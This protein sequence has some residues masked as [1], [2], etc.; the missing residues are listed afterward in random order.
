MRKTVFLIPFLFYTVLALSQPQPCGQNPEMTS[1]CSTACVVCDIDGFTGINDLTAQGQGFDEFMDLDCT[2]QFNNMQYIA[3]IAGSTNLTIEVDVGQCTGGWPSLEVGFFESLDCET[4]TAITPCDTDIESFQSQTFSNYDP[5]VIG[6]HYYLVIDGSGGANCQWTFNVLEGTTEVL[7][8][9]S[10]GVIDHPIETCP[11]QQITFFAQE[12]TGA[13]IFLWTINDES[14]TTFLSNLDYSFDDVGTYEV[15]VIAANVC[16]SAPPSCSTILVREI[17]NSTESFILCDGECA[18]VNG[19]DFCETGVFS[20][21]VELPG[22]CDSTIFVE[23]EVLPQAT[24]NADVWICNDDQFFIG[25]SAYNMSGSYSG[26]VLTQFDCD[27]LVNLE[28]LVIECEII[29]TPE[30]IPVICNGTATG[31]LIFSVDQGEPPLSYTWTNIADASITGDGTTPLLTNNEILNVPAG[32]YQIY[33]S[34]DFGNDVV[35]IQEVTEPPVLEIELEVSD[36]G[37][38]NVSCDMNDGAPGDDGTLEAFL[39]GG[40]PPYT[41]E[42]SDGQSNQFAENLSHE[43]YSLTVTDAVGCSIVASYE[44][45][46]PPPIEGDINFVDPNCDG[47]E[48][49]IIEVV[50]VDGGTPLYSYSLSNGNFSDQQLFEQLPEGD[51]SLFVQDA[52]D[53]IVEI[54]GTLT[55]PQ[56]PEIFIDSIYTVLLGDSI[57]LNPFFNDAE[58]ISHSWEDASTLDCDDCPYPFARPFNNI[59]YELEVTSVDDCTDREVVN[60]RV[61][62]RYRVYIP[63]IFTPDNDGFN[64]LFTVY[65]G[66]EVSQIDDFSVYDRWGNRLYFNSNFTANDESS[67]WDGK[68]RGERVM[69]GVYSWI[70]NVSFIDDESKVYVGSVTVVN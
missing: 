5:L 66:P 63:N 20:E 8:L 58:L 22:G 28:L 16:N 1:F 47:F 31:T 37:G 3:F 13:D 68:F 4:F 26:I 30:Q 24:T 70:A 27:S 67:G 56:I 19:N 34:D 65:G 49:G 25:D 44:L 57:Q 38:F 18:T 36:Y 51:Y 29:G 17:G 69:A 11:G 10:S 52:N 41:Y 59:T 12:Q 2:T 61:E 46:G 43:E 14:Q 64:D 60:V 48:T 7:P 50:D 21:I 40:V 55:A 35:V 32:V 23:V 42:W 45:T 6:R 9:E 53:C 15:C 39:I 54:T 62:K 33:I